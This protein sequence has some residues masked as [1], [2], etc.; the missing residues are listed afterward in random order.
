MREGAGAGQA[1][2]VNKKKSD[3]ETKVSK[4]NK[5]DC[6]EAAFKKKKKPV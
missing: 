1:T 4:E 5:L 2:S 3:C 6:R